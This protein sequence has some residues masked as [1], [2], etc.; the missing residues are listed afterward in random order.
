MQKIIVWV[1]VLLLLL[2]PGVLAVSISDLIDD[3][4]KSSNLDE[5]DRYVK[6][7]DNSEFKSFSFSDTTK[8][9]ASG[10][11]AFNLSNILKSILKLFLNEV[12]SVS[13]ILLQI[14]AIVLLFSILNNLNSSFTNHSVSNATFFGCYALLAGVML[15]A[16]WQSIE[17]GKG[18]ID[19]ASTFVGGIV[20]IMVTLM[21]SSGAIAS[22]AAIKPLVLASIQILTYIIKFVI[23]PILCATVTLCVV[24]NM[25]EKFSVSRFIGLFKSIIKYSLGIITVIFTVVMMLQSFCSVALDGATTKAVKYAMG[26]FVPVVG[27]VLSETIDTLA[28]CSVII[29]NAAGTAGIIAILMILC[30]PIIKTAALWAIF[31]ISAAITQP[32]SENRISASLDTMGDILGLMASSVFAVAVMFI[33]SL[34]MIIM[35]GNSVVMMR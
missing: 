32:I 11:S 33:I 21:V 25:S 13:W 10:E 23:V 17:I 22:S 28:G 4:T 18:A 3:Q 30:T 24:D 19:S 5:L 14:I 34:C 15:N 7:M 16:F 27:S 8:K 6:D 2:S 20:P 12:Y 1:I 29:K 31:K 35:A 26:S 9:I